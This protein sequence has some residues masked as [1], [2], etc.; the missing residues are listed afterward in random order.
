MRAIIRAIAGHAQAIQRVEDAQEALVA[1]CRMHALSKEYLRQARDR[2]KID[3]GDHRVLY[4]IENDNHESY[5]HYV[6]EG[7]YHANMPALLAEFSARYWVGQP[8]TR[9]NFLYDHDTAGL[10]AFWE[11]TLRWKEFGVDVLAAH[12]LRDLDSD[13]I[14]GGTL[15]FD[16]PHSDECERAFAIWL[17]QVKG[18]R[19]LMLT[20]INIAESPTSRHALHHI[21]TLDLPPGRKKEQ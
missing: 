1:A 4:A 15:P 19:P 16:A 18:F 14:E 8:K 20:I 9:N 10:H 5:P 13:E 11:S 2:H 7:P 3:K 12:P 17:C 6:L 21:E